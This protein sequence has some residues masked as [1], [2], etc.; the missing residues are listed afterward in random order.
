MIAEKCYECEQTVDKIHLAK[1]TICFK[2]YCDEHSF[3][4]NGRTFCSKGCAQYFFFSDDDTDV[5]KE[6]AE[7]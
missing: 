2:Y 3:D 6:D 1:C 4:M 7:G 5:D